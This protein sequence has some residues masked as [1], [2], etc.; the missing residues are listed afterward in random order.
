MFDIRFHR[1]IMHHRH[2][3]EK[4][5]ELEKAYLEVDLLFVERVFSE[6]LT[7][8][9]NAIHLIERLRIVKIDVRQVVKKFSHRQNEV[10]ETSQSYQFQ[11]IE[12]LISW[13]FQVQSS[14]QHFSCFCAARQD[15]S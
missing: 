8:S 7:F 12:L 3:D 13:Y 1:F 14:Q 2:T 5:R 10:S 4:T 9:I 15:S 11:V 6:V